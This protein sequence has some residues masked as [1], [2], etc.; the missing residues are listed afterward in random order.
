MYFDKAGIEN[1]DLTI[2][3]AMNYAAMHGIKDLVVAS[4][5]GFT[6]D[7]IAQTP[8]R[9]AFN[10][11]V[12]THNTG[13]K[14][15]GTQSFPPDV[16]QSLIQGGMKVHTGTMV[17][18]SLGT[19]I[20]DLA[21]GYSE[22]ELVAN[23]LRMFSQGI[24]VCVEITAMAAD[25]GLIPFSDVIAIAGTGRGADT[26]C[27]IRANSSNRFFKIKIREIIAKPKEF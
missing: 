7:K 16:R 27:L 23:T 6:A 18:R 17:L 1:T 3:I 10:L 13:F 26:V 4:T 12:V 24:K 19:A 21:G 8:G 22:Q 15:E 25:A 9:E 14:E 2:K 5:T 20:R 11:V